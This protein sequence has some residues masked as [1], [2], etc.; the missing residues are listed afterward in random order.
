MLVFFQISHAF[1]PSSCLIY[2]LAQP[3]TGGEQRQAHFRSD[4]NSHTKSASMQPQT[5]LGILMNGS[6]SATTEVPA[7]TTFAYLTPDQ[8]ARM[9]EDLKDREQQASALAAAGMVADNVSYTR[10]AATSV[11]QVLQAPPALV[12]MPLHSPAAIPLSSVFA[13]NNIHTTTTTTLAAMTTQ[14]INNSINNNGPPILDN[15]N[16][17]LDAGVGP[18]AMLGGAGI[19]DIDMDFSTLFDSE[20]QILVEGG[21]GLDVITAVP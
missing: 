18:G 13:N 3:Q 2:S 1:S 21:G 17:N 8:Q 5:G 14:N 4:S 19:D 6:A 16:W 11:G 12:G 7:T 20:E 9:H 15:I 10:P